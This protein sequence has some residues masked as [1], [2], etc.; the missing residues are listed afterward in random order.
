MRV[1]KGKDEEVSQEI[2]GKKERIKQR[3]FHQIYMNISFINPSNFALNFVMCNVSTAHVY[4][5]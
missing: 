3:K 5:A 1:Q 4:N 2:K